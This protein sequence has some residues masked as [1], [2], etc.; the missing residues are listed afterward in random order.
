MRNVRIV[1]VVI[2]IL[3]PYL[4]RLPGIPTHGAQ[5]LVSY[6][7]TGIG[8]VLF[9]GVFNAINWGAIAIA[10]RSYDHPRSAWFP[11]VLGFAL[12]VWA[13]SMLD[14]SSDAQA[15]IALVFIPIYSLPL[16]LAGWQLGRWF[17][18]WYDRRLMQS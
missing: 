5:W 17:D 4:A 6:F 12:P 13:H 7:G 16:V 8:A 1:I 11:V 9:V 15:G 18:R 2:G 10:T 14:L 3:L